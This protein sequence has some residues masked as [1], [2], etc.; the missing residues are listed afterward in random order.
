M[1]YKQGYFDATQD[2]ISMFQSKIAKN[3]NR[4]RGLNVLLARYTDVDYRIGLGE[5]K[6]KCRGIK[7]ELKQLHKENMLLKK[8]MKMI[9]NKSH[10]DRYYVELKFQS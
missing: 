6:S 3:S 10:V 8:N 1:S 7:K 9:M 5:Y 2:I 4:I